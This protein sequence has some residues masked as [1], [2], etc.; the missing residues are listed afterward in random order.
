MPMA[1]PWP[2]GLWAYVGGAAAG[3]G[4]GS[5]GVPRDGIEKPRARRWWGRPSAWSGLGALGAVGERARCGSARMR[6]P[7]CAG[8]A[9]KKAAYA[10]A[11]YRWLSPASLSPTL[12][13]CPRHYCVSGGLS[14]PA[15]PLP[16]PLTCRGGCF[17]L[18][19]PLTPLGGQVVTDDCS[20]TR[21]RLAFSASAV[22]SFAGEL[23]FW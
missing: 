14:P 22:A 5:W 10:V 12:I 13:V 2:T 4:E 20:R 16:P 6:L 21:S 7:W 11:G 18:L 15:A 1:P 17:F 8:S 19:L 9:W 3:H 23:S